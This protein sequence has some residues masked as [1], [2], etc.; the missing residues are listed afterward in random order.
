LVHIRL[1]TMAFHS[2]VFQS[3]AK[4]TI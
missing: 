3:L 4:F 2:E 1:L